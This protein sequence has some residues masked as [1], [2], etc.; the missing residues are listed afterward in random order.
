MSERDSNRFSFAFN[1]DFQE[2]IRRVSKQPDDFLILDLSDIRIVAQN[3]VA[4]FD[5][6]NGL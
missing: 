4:R 5:F 2:N 3:L 6:L 1:L